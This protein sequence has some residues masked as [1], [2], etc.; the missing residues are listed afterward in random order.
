MPNINEAFPSK[1]LS[2]SDLLGRPVR[3]FVE[4]FEWAAMNDGKRKL[5][6]FFQGKTKGLALNKTN[7]NIIQNSYGPD[8]DNW[9]GAEIEL[10][11]TEVDFQGKQ[12]QAIRVKIPPR[13]PAPKQAARPTQPMQQAAPQ[14]RVQEPDFSDDI[15]F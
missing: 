12:V 11:P 5:I 1:Y 14:Q 6:M 2:A 3:A 15:P 13:Q 10:Y 9:I 4:R 8:T 7:A